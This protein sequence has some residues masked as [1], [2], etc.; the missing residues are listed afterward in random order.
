[1]AA[2][3]S[4][5]LASAAATL[6]GLGTSVINCPAIHAARS[7]DNARTEPVSAHRAGMGDIARCV[8]TFYV[9][10]KEKPNWSLRSDTETQRPFQMN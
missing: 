10:L 7:T 9:D 4:V 2:T 6:A 3:G 5:S 8:S 1:M